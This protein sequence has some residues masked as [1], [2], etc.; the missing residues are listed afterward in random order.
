LN[1]VLVI[2]PG[3]AGKSVFAARLAERTGLPLLHLDAHYWRPG[4]IEPS[5]G[6]WN[7]TVEQLV[8]GER[9][10]MDGN[11]GGTL[12]R[13]LAAC[14]TVVFL[15]ASRWLCLWRVIKRRLQHRGRAR[16]DMTPG[17]NERLS[18]DF[19]WWIWTYPSRRKPKILRMLGELRAD[20]TAIILR[21]SPE[22]EHFLERCTTPPADQPA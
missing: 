6:E 14:D 3:G 15:D 21:T 1:R 9:W 16:P 10:I 12:V 20:Q 17:C 11:Y 22:I 18:L 8:A 2:G 19:L 7:A 4:W 13:R 5:K